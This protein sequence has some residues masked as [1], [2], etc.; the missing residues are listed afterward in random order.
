MTLVN[1]GG[2]WRAEDESQQTG[3]TEE[4]NKTTDNVIPPDPFNTGGG[5]PGVPSG[6]PLSDF[7]SGAGSN[8]DFINTGGAEW[9]TAADGEYVESPGG[10]MFLLEYVDRT[11]K[12]YRR[13]VPAGRYI[14]TVIVIEGKVAVADVTEEGEVDSA[15]EK[16]LGPGEELSVEREVGEEDS[17]RDRIYKAIDSLSS[18]KKRQLLRLI[19]PEEPRK[20]KPDKEKKDLAEKVDAK[21]PEAELIEHFVPEAAP[22]QLLPAGPAPGMLQPELAAEPGKGINIDPLVD[23]IYDSYKALDMIAETKDQANAQIDI[24]TGPSSTEDEKVDAVE[25]IFDQVEGIR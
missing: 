16:L 11:G 13:L 21:T 1:V 3:S 24:L 25:N 22:G 15:N 14:T 20:A 10:L 12:K 6:D 7:S 19:F 2:N 9:A 17:L 8:G 18:D 23:R 4:I 5:G